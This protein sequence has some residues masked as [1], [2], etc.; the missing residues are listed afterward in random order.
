MIGFVNT[1][2]EKKT[3]GGEIVR[4]QRK[5][6]KIGWSIAGAIFFIIFNLV[7]YFLSKI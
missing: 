1:D 2:K 7:L 6:R 5:M 4:H 3:M